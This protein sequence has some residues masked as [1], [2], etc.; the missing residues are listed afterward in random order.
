MP[1]RW[2]SRRARAR[3]SAAAAG[4]AIA[5]GAGLARAPAASAAT[6]LERRV[7]V[8]I[9]ADGTVREQTALSVRLDGPGDVEA[10]STYAVYVDDHRKLLDADGAA[11]H[12]DG[13]RQRV[14]RRHRDE[15]AAP[16]R[17]V[18]H[19]SSRYHLLEIPGAR[20][21]S[22]VE[23]E[24]AVEVDPYYPAGA[25][26]LRGDDRVERLRVEVRGGGAGWRWRIDGP[27][28]G[29]AAAESAGGVVVTG[30]GLEPPDPPPASPGGAARYPVLRYGWG[31]EGTWQSVGR[32][33][34]GLLATLPR[35][36]PAVR[37][38]A[39]A[40]AVDD[41]RATLEALTATVQEQVRYVAVEVGIGG[42]RP[43]PPAE[44]LERAWGDC[45]D[46]GLL[47][48]DLL[49]EVGIPA[50]PALALLA[51]D[52]RIDPEFP[53]PGQFNHVIVAVPATAVEVGDGDAVAGGYLFVDPTQPA[54]GARWL[55]PGTQGHH[56]LVVTPSGGE[57]VRLPVLP[58]SEATELV[59]NLHL[60]PRGDAAG[61]AGLRVH[62]Q[63]AQALL[64]RTGGGEGAGEGALRG[65]LGRLLPG[66]DLG[67]VGWTA[68]EGPAPA[69]DLA[70]AVKIPRLLEGAGD[71]SSLRLPALRSAPEP[72]LLADRT[73]PLV[74]D[75]GRHAVTW[76]VALP[77]GCIAPDDDEVSAANDA[78]SFRQTV[79]RRGEG[80]FTLEREIV[81]AERWYGPELLPALAELSLAE[82][83]AHRR[84]LRFSCPPAN[85]PPPP[86]RSH[87]R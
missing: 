5:L 61:G 20:V 39:R 71:R 13:K 19:E 85:P 1:S 15:I 29:L 77:V 59:V 52:H 56:A 47:L 26:Q 36:E 3:A 18:F 54:G 55:G 34:E 21:G 25:V 33:Y 22:T 72:R 84:R 86:G 53:S 48:V 23:I 64:D 7:T 10:W 38:R 24:T 12:P 67:T 4:A 6:V 32:W 49:A 27:S 30:S 81:L 68:G 41:R 65:V 44:T 45:K 80:A 70:A 28:D 37:E 75:A 46:K 79:T 35:A 82:Y 57:L 40:L 9:G 51:S 73:E 87:R 42:F 62:G 17:G 50:H 16:D 78:G 60:D 69:I 8:E 63:L 66:A 83:R 58:E 74:T 43:S 31:D 76:H 2:C 14:K 11:V